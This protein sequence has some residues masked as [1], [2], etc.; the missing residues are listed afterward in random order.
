[1]RTTSRTWIANPAAAWTSDDNADCRGGIVVEGKRIVECVP[2]GHT[3]A[4]YSERFDARGLVLLPGLVNCHHHFYQTLTR[5]LPAAQN[6]ELFAWLSALYPVWAGMD[7]DCVGSATE[8]ALAELLL[9][10]C[11]TASDHHY[12]FASAFENAIDIQVETARRM[13]VRVVLTRGSM[14]LGQSS[15]G[16]PPDHVVQSE[17]AILDDCQRVASAYHERGDDA[18]VQIALAPCSPFSVTA[19]LMRESAKLAR[20]HGLRLHTHLAET[21]D[22]NAFCLEHVGRRPLEYLADLDWLGDDVWLAHGIHFTA[23]EIAQLGT[24]GVG[25][26]HCPSS[27]MILAS[28]LCSTLDLEAA[29]SPVGLGVDGSASNDHSNLIQEVRQAFLLQRLKYGS[30]KIAVTDALRW[31]TSGGARVLGRPSLGSLRPG[32][33]ADIALFDLDALRFSG[34]GDPLAALVTCGADRARHVMVNGQWRV[35]DGEIPGLD[36]GALVARHGK[37]ARRLQLG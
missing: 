21:E 3:P 28:G 9:S 8:L 26:C 29:G 27:N 18:M 33:L 24:A 37:A 15:G 7:E 2:G 14:S 25:I 34:A 35:V 16:L 31:A 6:K 5:A 1:M 22:E 19:E 11:T 23:E 17:Q 12:L 20:A 13:G 4:D 30:E 10:G 36:M 32:A